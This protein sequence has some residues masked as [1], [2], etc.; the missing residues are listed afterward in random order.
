MWYNKMSVSRWYGLEPL[1]RTCSLVYVANR[2]YG[3]HLLNWGLDR[4]YQHLFINELD[5]NNF[6]EE[7]K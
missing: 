1:K 4:P 7:L 6:F 5:R 2:T 3:I